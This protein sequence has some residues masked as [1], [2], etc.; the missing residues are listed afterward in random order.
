MTIDRTRQNID[1]VLQELRE[2]FPGAE[3][4]PHEPGAGAGTKFI[5]RT[6]GQERR[7][8]RLS[9]ECLADTESGVLIERMQ[10]DRV[11]ERLRG[12]ESLLMTNEGTAPE[13]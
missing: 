3:V 5:I 9:E 1:A 7:W 2:A 11:G 4:T 13:N 6:P 8:L 10:S 12:G